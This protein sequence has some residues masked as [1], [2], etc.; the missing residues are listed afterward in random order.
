[1]KATDK[2][3]KQTPDLLK[4]LVGRPATGKALSG[5]ERIAKLRAERKAQG[6]CICCGQPLPNID[7]ASKVGA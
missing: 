7:N 5:A 3:A 4:R 6:L 1:M 2:N